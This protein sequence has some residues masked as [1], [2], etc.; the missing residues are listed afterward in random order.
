[1]VACALCDNLTQYQ[2]SDR[3]LEAIFF[4]IFYSVKCAVRATGTA[5]RALFDSFC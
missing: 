5:A 3:V 1:M 4:L 2:Y